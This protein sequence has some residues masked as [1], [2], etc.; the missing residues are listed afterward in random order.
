MKKKK[1]ENSVKDREKRRW[2][3]MSTKGEKRVGEYNCGM[4]WPQINMIKSVWQHC[5]VSYT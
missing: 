5:C 2:K 1:K 3:D 4:S